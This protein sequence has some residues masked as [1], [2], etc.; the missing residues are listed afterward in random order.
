MAGA[1]LAQD[2]GSIW[3]R[4][5]REESIHNGGTIRFSVQELDEVEIKDV[6]VLPAA[7]LNPKER[8]EQRNEDATS[9]LV[10]SHD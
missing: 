7:K 9:M 2:S 5:S 1:Q 6:G 10:R 8:S 3:I 4:G